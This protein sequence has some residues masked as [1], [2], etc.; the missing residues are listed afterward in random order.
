M[1][2]DLQN[3]PS[4][5]DQIDVV[6]TP[7]QND[8][9]SFV[10]TVSELVKNAKYD[11]KSE[12]V[13]PTGTTDELAY[14][15]KLYTQ[16]KKA[17][18]GLMKS[19]QSVASLT[20]QNKVLESKVQSLL[21]KGAFSRLDSD[22]KTRLTELKSTDPE[23]WRAEMDQLETKMVTATD[24]DLKKELSV[25]GSKAIIKARSKLLDLYNDANPTRRITQ[26]VIDKDIPPRIKDKLANNTI[27]FSTFL[28]EVSDYMTKGKRV[29]TDKVV[30][31]DDFKATG[32]A[33]ASSKTA[34]VSDYENL[35][36]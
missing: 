25:A 16:N 4:S 2:L 6:E 36:I 3:S 22:A 12:L 10:D 33:Y 29:A 13:I 18:S 17:Q 9:V 14:A 28:S 5:A 8:K 7:P 20:A 35:I 23:A 32:E 1:N 31:T 30:K 24:E 26:E 34:K 15:T 11:D 21:A 27:D 19:E